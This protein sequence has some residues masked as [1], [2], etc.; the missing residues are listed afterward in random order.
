MEIRYLGSIIYEIHL[1]RPRSIVSSFKK[2][3]PDISSKIPSPRFCSMPR[4]LPVCIVSLVL[5]KALSTLL[6]SNSKNRN[7]TYDK[8]SISFVDFFQQ[9]FINQIYSTNKILISDK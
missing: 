1:F 5:E 3:K 2:R 7:Q 9:I 4:P 8:S 6:L